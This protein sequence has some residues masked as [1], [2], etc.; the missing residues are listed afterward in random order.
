CDAILKETSLKQNDRYMRYAYLIKATTYQ[1]LSQLDNAIAACDAAIKL[2]IGVLEPYLT[3]A[4]IYT[5]VEQWEKALQVYDQIIEDPMI[6]KNDLL[7]VVF[8]GRGHMNL[9]RMDW[10]AAQKDFQRAFDLDNK[11]SQ[12]ITGLAI[13]MVYNHE[14]KKAI[15]FVK[16]QLKNFDKDGLFHYN[17][18]CVYGRALINL[19][20]QNKTPDVQKTIKCYQDTA[21]Q[22]LSHA[23][24]YG[25]QDVEWMQ[26]DPDLSELQSLPS[27]KALVQRLE[28][29][30]NPLQ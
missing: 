27:F 3:K 21:I 5:E 18:A 17:V 25:F 11:S 19:K 30:G 9:Q 22:H 2:S 28:K 12:A 15:S 13:C 24:Q 8:N 4:Q 16:E 29:Q 10:Q 7:K 20:D 14:E 1:Q 26:K 6:Q 23:A